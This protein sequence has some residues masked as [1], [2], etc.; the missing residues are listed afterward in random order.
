MKYRLS[1]HW[2]ATAGDPYYPL[3]CR[4]DDY[5]WCN[6]TP[7]GEL[8]PAVQFERFREGLDDYRRLITLERLAKERSDTPAAKQARKLID[9]ILGTFELGDREPR[10]AETFAQLR[11]RLDAAIESLR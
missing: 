3:D 6:S 8:I 9:E 2:N 11:G 4:E 5:A 10:S 7:D 1:W